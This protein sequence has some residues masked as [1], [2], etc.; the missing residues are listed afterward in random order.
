MGRTGHIA[1][2][3]L[4]QF[5]FISRA[6][7]CTPLSY[8][9]L[10]SEI[11]NAIHESSDINICARIELYRTLPLCFN[12]D[13]YRVWQSNDSLSIRP[14]VLRMSRRDV[15]NFRD[16]IQDE[17]TSD[18]IN[19]DSLFASYIRNRIAKHDRRLIR[20]RDEREVHK[21]AQ[22]CSHPNC[23]G[24]LQRAGKYENMKK[25]R[26]SKRK[27]PRKISPIVILAQIHGKNTHFC[28]LRS[29]LIGEICN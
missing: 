21:P 23:T 13:A 14:Q 6:V 15:F 17:T 11:S 22:F 7:H 25:S 28:K 2:R 8:V 10:H 3:T 26:L 4:Y 19:N 24:R 5:Q 18:I 29:I 1:S 12:P 27:V 20:R 9:N 16:I